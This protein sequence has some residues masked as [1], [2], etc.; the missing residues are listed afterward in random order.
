MTQPD[1]SDRIV[2]FVDILGFEALVR[3]LDSEPELHNK[4]HQALASIGSYKQSSLSEN[5]AQSALEVSVFSDSIVVSGTPNDA[6]SVIWSVL[7]LQCSLLALA[8]PSRGG[9]A[10]GHTVHTDE[11]LYGVG[12]LNA[13]HLEQS[14]A[15]YPRVVIDPNLVGEL[16]AGFRAM[17]LKQ[18]ADALWFVDP[19]AMGILPGNSAALL[20]DGYDPHEESLKQL[21]QRI[22][23]EIERLTD[24]G[25]LAKWNWLKRQHSMAVVEFTKFGKPRFWHIWS[26]IENR[27]KGA[28]KAPMNRSGNPPSFP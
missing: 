3:R 13:Y 10:R 22:D 14:A 17:F 9:I 5:T 16:D 8:I 23:Q 21:G 11:I 4:L 24:A 18:D 7:H 15:V 26:D 2:A 20:E 6:R 12:F 25:H 19:F 1:Y 27:E 28:T